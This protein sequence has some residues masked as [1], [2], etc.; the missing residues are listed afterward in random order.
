MT[1]N[2]NVTN[3]TFMN[4]KLQIIWSHTNSH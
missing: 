4:L 1:L 2:N 3:A